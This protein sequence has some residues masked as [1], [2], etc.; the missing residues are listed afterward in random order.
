MRIVG[1]LLAKNEERFVERAVKNAIGFCDEFLAVDNGSTD[2]TTEILKSLE[3]S[4]GGKL[5]YHQA[6]HPRVSHDLIAGLAG[7]KTWVFGVDADEIYDPAGLGRFR[8][9]LEGGEFD[10]DWCI[11]GNVLNVRH[12][13]GC[14]AEGHLAPPCRS[15]TK[16]YNFSAIHAWKGP[17]LERLHG[18]RVDFREGYGDHLRRDLHQGISWEVADFRCLHVCFLPRS[19]VD[20]RGSGPRKNIMDMYNWSL[21]KAAGGL[22]DRLRGRPEIDWKEQR[23]GRGPL[24]K[25]EVAAFFS[26]EGP[27]A[28]ELC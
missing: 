28:G 13:D 26:D 15:M 5:K 11:F 1:I 2:R 9:R 20:D 24:V 19:P 12:L 25:R 7:S 18:G 4:S 16:L 10:R 8:T 17:C 23:Y 22:W 6:S 3:A 27:T 14:F 21:R